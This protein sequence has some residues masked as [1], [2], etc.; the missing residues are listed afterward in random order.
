MMVHKNCKLSKVLSIKS[1]CQSA[2]F[3]AAFAGGT[4]SYAASVLT[5]ENYNNAPHYYVFGMNGDGGI[6]VDGGDEFT[7]SGNPAS[8]P[9]TSVHNSGI[10]FARQTGSTGTGF[11]SGSGSAITVRCA[12]YI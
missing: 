2:I 7:W 8:P 5:G 3:F 11:I 9:D 12:C 6:T 1:V 10:I 4:S